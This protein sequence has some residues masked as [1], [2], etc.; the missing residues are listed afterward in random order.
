MLLRTSYLINPRGALLADGIQAPMEVAL[1]EGL[2][3]RFTDDG[4][5]VGLTLERPVDPA[6]L[7][8]MTDPNS[9]RPLSDG[10]YEP[11][12]CLRLAGDRGGDGAIAQDLS[13]A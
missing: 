3:A 4:T 13:T 1:E 10:T 6:A 8:F 5:H 2:I 7:E 9:Q 11:V 12:P